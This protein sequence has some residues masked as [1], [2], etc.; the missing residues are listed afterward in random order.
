MI[1]VERSGSTAVLRMAHGKVNALDVE[2]CQ[3]IPETLKRVFEDGYRAVVLTAEGPVFSAGVDLFRIL[4]GGPDYA[5]RLLASLSEALL[6]LFRFPLPVVAAVNGHAIAGGAVIACACDYRLA[7]DGPARIGV[8][9]LAVGVPYPLSVLEIVRYAT[10]SHAEE[11][12]FTARTYPPAEAQHRG[13]L[14][15]VVPAQEL[16]SRAMSTAETLGQVHP[17]AYQATKHGLRGPLIDMVVREQPV[18]DAQ[19]RRL[20]SAPEAIASIR[21]YMDRL[22]A[23]A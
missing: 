13:F 11:V 9:E 12:I 15:E 18:F 6:A 1:S 14:H 23:K 17:A 7:A 4:D 19:I 21:G 3:A 8:S 22:R 5:D 10:G 2:M 20:W 16:L